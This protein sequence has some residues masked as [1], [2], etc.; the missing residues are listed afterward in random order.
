[1]G[2]IRLRAILILMGLVL[3]SVAT[4]PRV[5]A[6]PVPVTSSWLT[7]PVAL[8]GGITNPD[9][10]SDTIPQDLTLLESGIGPTNASARVWMK[11]DGTWL[12]LLE[13]VKWVGGVPHSADDWDAGDVE[14]FWPFWHGYWDHS[15]LG[16]V[17][18]DNTTMDFYGW[19][20][21]IWYDDVSAGGQNNTQGAV[22]HDGTNYWFEFRKPLSSEDGY[23]P[24]TGYG[25][26][27]SFVPGGTYGQEPPSLLVGFW[28][29]STQTYYYANI[30]LHLSSPDMPVTCYSLVEPVTIDGKWTSATEW[31]D[32]A[33]VRM[34]VGEGNAVGYF[35]IKHDA[36]YVYVL[37]ESL[38]DTAVEQ[39]DWMQVFFDTLHNHG[40]PSADDYRFLAV[41][42]TSTSMDVRNWKGNGTGWSPLNPLLAGA[43]AK[44]GLD[45]GNSPHAPYPHFVG[46]FKIPLSVGITLGSE[47]GFFIHLGD[48]H[49]DLLSMHFYWPGPSLAPEMYDPSSWG[50]VLLSRAELGYS[51]VELRLVAGWNLVSLPLVPRTNAITSVLN[52]L[53]ASNEVAVVW[54]YTGAPRTW[55]FYIPGKAS[56]LTVMN[57]GEGYWIYMRAADMLGVSG[58]VIPPA[59]TPPTYTLLTGW[60]LVGFK[61]QPDIENKT[62]SDYLLSLTDNYDPN[63]IWILDNSSGN[64]IR[65]TD[66]TWIRPGEA[67]WILITAPSGTTLKP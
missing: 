54:S 36:S 21:T 65:A 31:R 40:L 49:D 12:Y 56:T 14:Y 32:A 10:W 11:N 4:F 30:E 53:I 42:M 19:D 29:N 52:A 46:E 60:N 61:P 16:G 13:R 27:W 44:I 20:E 8:D 25:R 17:N 48:S 41:W 45:T 47:F 37:M 26:D 64:W 28:D 6:Q 43:Q 59:V 51:L 66:S 9:E 1:M 15:D 35:R 57:D 50:D 7:K 22:T 3:A 58:T 63:N 5:Q 34:Y 67:M 24:D 55:K 23:D 2:S 62:V 18:F 38:A 39:W 33:E